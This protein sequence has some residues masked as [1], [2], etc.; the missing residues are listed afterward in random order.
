[1][2]L[3]LITISA[4]L[5]A[6]AA[7]PDCAPIEGSTAILDDPAIDYVVFGETHGT[8][9]SPALFS[10]L[11][12]A[13]AARGPVMVALE[14]QLADEPVF[15]TW[16][17]SNGDAAARAALLRA[18]LWN[19]RMKDGR[20]SVA[21]LALAERLRRMFEAKQ[22]LGVVGTLDPAA[23][24]PNDQTPHDRAIAANWMRARAAYPGARV[25]ALVGSAHAVAGRVDFGGG[26]G[27]MSAASFLP[28]EHAATLGP[29]DAGGL[30]WVCQ[31]MDDC[32]PHPAG[33]GSQAWPRSIRLSP[34]GRVGP[35]HWDYRYAPGGAFTAAA[36]A[37]PVP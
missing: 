9:E 26:H 23:Y 32:G 27:F 16:L 3:G 2:A 33:T 34:E 36:P 24:D 37:K 25:L 12:C 6:V 1:M 35:L 20:S 21:M 15:A 8:T 17:A 19:D 7:A 13:A 31:S 4:W 18:G 11:V 22:I 29:A 28:R 5:L 30:A 10:D 14:I